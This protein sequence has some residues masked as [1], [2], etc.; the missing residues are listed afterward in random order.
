MNKTTFTNAFTKTK[1]TFTSFTPGQRAVTVI[2]LLA[3]IVGGIFFY[4]WASAPTMTPVFT[5]LSAQDA[6]AVTAKLDELGTKYELADGGKSVLVAQEDV[7]KAR[8]DLASAGLPKNTDQSQGYALLDN[9]SFATSDFQQKM[10]AKRATEG[11]LQKAI[12]S[13]GPVDKAQVQLA[14]PEEEVFTQ[15][16]PPTTASVLVT[17]KPSQELNAGQVEAIVHLVS[18]SVPKLQA[19]N[20]T[21]TDSTGRLLSSA[22]MA[23]GASSIGDQRVAQAQ[24]LAMASQQKIQAMLDKAVG[25]GN[26]SVT[27][28]ADLNFD[29][30]T[31]EENGYV[32]PAQPNALPVQEQTE[33][34]TLK[35]NGQTPVGGVLGPDN[36]TVPGANAGQSNQDYRTEKST[37]TNAVGTK[38]TVTE[39]APGRVSRMSVAVMLNANKAAALNQT[40]MEG[41]VAAAAG[42]DTKRGDA[43]KVSRVPFDT[44]AAT[45]AAAAKAAAEEAERQNE[46]IELAKN[47]G[48]ALLLLLALLIGF[49]KSRKKTRTVEVGDL[50]SVETAELL[51]EAHGSTAAMPEL[52]PPP[53]EYAL[54]DDEMPV[55][56]AT[57]LDPQ[58]EAR[59][60]ARSEINALVE[61][62]PDEVARLLRGWI[63]ERN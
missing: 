48:L 31:I 12:E 60:A 18:A 46:L 25:P 26:S 55:I 43:L 7:N 8:I 50:Q 5:N 21:V 14:L 11:E 10:S 37:K 47:I 52:L 6:G 58:T 29:N 15:Q 56:E 13:L 28:T 41:L 3:A 30:T 22:G 42:I 4:Q 24:T 1:Q 39:L 19:G 20:V 57:P 2:A 23:G 9:Q 49:R 61:E 54:E 45:D 63:A 16:Q 40:D 27:V 34:E 32:Q 51:P 44:Q 53:A 35:G 17:P 36:I 33:K 38:R 62:N 59:T